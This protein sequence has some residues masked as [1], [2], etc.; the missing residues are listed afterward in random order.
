MPIYEFQCA[1]CAHKFEC[2][3]SREELAQVR[4]P[5]CGASRVRR[6]W[7]VFSAGGSA[8]QGGSGCTACTS[9]R[10]STCH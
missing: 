10:C 1:G 4:C 5:A 7:S 9:R 6:L 3:A 2:L 8:S